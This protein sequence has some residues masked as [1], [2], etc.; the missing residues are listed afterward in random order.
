MSANEGSAEGS[1]NCT[2]LPL[3]TEPGLLGSV[4]A[5]AEFGLVMFVTDGPKEQGPAAI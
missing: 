1:G 5:Q 2:S 4:A 3:K